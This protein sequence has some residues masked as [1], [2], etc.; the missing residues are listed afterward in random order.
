MNGSVELLNEFSQG[1]SRTE[2]AH[3][4]LVIC[5]PSIMLPHA[6]SLERDFAVGAQDCSHANSGAFTGDISA[7][8]LADFGVKYVLT[9][10]SERRRY[11]KETNDKCVSKVNVAQNSGLTPIFCIGETLADYQSNL[12]MDVL[13]NQLESLLVHNI[14]FENLV[15]AYEPIWAI[16]SGLVPSLN[17]I[18][19]TVD[20][21]KDWIIRSKGRVHGDGMRLLYGGSVSSENSGAIL[22]LPNVGGLLIGGASLKHPSFRLIA[23]SAY[24]HLKSA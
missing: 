20:F 2:W 12:T 3:A 5:P 19:Q 23:S 17:T 14:D 13:S 11:Q 1:R 16:G 9:G 10:H 6:V 21:I 18:S 8:M 4:E 7:N 15:I 22:S 24:R